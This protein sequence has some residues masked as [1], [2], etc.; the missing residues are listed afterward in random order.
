MYS[1]GALYCI[2]VISVKV[3][4][5]PKLRQGSH[6]QEHAADRPTGESGNQ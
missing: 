6:N 4:R 2:A 5:N 1:S 3:G